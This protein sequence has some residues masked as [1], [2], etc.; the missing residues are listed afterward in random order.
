MKRKIYKVLLSLDGVRKEDIEWNRVVNYCPK[1]LFTDEFVAAHE[2]ELLENDIVI[3]RP[4]ISIRK[5]LTMKFLKSID[6][7]HITNQEMYDLTSIA[8]H[9]KAMILH[10]KITEKECLL[11]VVNELMSF[12]IPGINIMVPYKFLTCESDIEFFSDTVNFN[13]IS[14]SK[15]GVALKNLFD[16]KY[17]SE[18]GNN[19]I[20]ELAIALHQNNIISAKHLC[21]LLDY[22]EVTPSDELLNQLSLYDRH[23]I[24]PDI[25]FYDDE[26]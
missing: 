9:V 8:R 23:E 7:K 26:D 3:Q 14:G 17:G 15:Y 25:E 18:N 6:R 5:G 19:K 11:E 20:Q 4:K 10:N 24:V 16:F 13:L 1:E 22:V 21:K 12:N 2:K